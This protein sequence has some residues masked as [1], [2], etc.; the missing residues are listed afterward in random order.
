MRAAAAATRKIPIPNTLSM[1]SA[2][3]VFDFD[4]AVIEGAIVGEVVDERRM[5]GDVRF[6]SVELIR[7]VG[8]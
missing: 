7:P 4:A 6:R 5:V 1:L 2:D 8:L 3:C